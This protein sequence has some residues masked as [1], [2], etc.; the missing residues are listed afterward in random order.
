MAKKKSNPD[1]RIE[2]KLDKFGVF[3]IDD[4]LF[5]IY[6]TLSE[7]TDSAILEF[8][9]SGLDTELIICKVT[10][11]RVIKPSSIVVEDL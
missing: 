5:G 7:A 10:P 9:D 6:P 4:E 2:V 11:V 1:Q 3:Y 8:T